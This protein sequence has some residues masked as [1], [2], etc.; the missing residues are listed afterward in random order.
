MCVWGAKQRRRKRN[1]FILEKLRKQLSTGHL[2]GS[3]QTVCAGDSLMF[4][5]ILRLSKEGEDTKTWSD[6]E[7]RQCILQNF[8]SDRP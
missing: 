6:V 7:K 5:G 3:L 8:A 2:I 1:L 4:F